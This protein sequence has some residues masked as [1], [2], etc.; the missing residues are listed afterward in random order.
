MQLNLA[1]L[2]LTQCRRVYVEGYEVQMKIGVYEHE[3]HSQQ[4]TIFNIDLYVPFELN[5]PKNDSLDEVVNYEFILE[6]VTLH[7]QNGHIQLQ[8]TLCDNIIETLLTHPKVM[9]ARVKTSKPEAFSDCL[10]VGV[11]VFRIKPS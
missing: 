1:P 8:E 5:T 2:D 10:S 6:T 7:T 3:K 4:R 11:E 9:A